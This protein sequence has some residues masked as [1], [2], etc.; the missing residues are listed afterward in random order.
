MAWRDGYT[1][2][3][4]D[5]MAWAA[6]HERNECKIL[7]AY[8]PGDPEYATALDLDGRFIAALEMEAFLR[9][10]P[11]DPATQA[12]IGDSM[13]T[14]RSLEKATR[15]SIQTIEAEAR[16]VGAK[17]PEELLYDRLQLPAIAG[18]LITHRKPKPTN[19]ND[20][21]PAAPMTPAQ[22]ARMI[23]EGK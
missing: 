2:R 11:N 4:E 15:L 1:P 23:L 8:V 13:E 17:S 7:V 14:R 18:N 9:F 16:A 5:R 20:L 22:V 3:P 12:Q 10:A 21:T 6:M 19:T